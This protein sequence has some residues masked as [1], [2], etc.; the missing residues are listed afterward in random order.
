VGLG[1][2]ASGARRVTDSM[3]VAAARA[4]SELSPAR[5]N[6]AASLYPALEDV[7]LASRQVALAVGREAQRVG[8]AAPSD[9]ADLVSRVDALMWEPRYAQLR[10]G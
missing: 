2:L 9:P 1:V 7:R 3:F 5:Q 8:V 4:L 6:P 10:R